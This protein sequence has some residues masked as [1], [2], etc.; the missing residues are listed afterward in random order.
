MVDSGVAGAR[1]GAFR[2]VL[3]VL[4]ADR[5][6]LVV[7]AAGTL[8]AS[9]SGLLVPWL[10]SSAIQ[11]LRAGRW[12]DVGAFAALFAGV[13]ILGA[14]VSAL[15]SLFLGR[16]AN[17]IVG[18]LRERS[19]R[20]AMAIPVSRLTRHPAGDLVSRCANDTEYLGA[21]YREG[22]IQA[23]GVAVVIV[24]AGVGMWLSDWLLCLLVLPL[25]GLVGTVAGVAARPVGRASL[26]HQRALGDFSAE[27]QRCLE[28]L[29]TIRANAADGFA[30]A[31]LGAAIRALV[32]AANRS[33]LARS[34]VGPIMLVS[35]QL[36]AGVVVAVVIWRSLSGG[37]DLDR[38]VA[39]FMYAGM[40]VNPLA[41][42]GSLM[43]AIAVAAG[44]L[45]RL[46][47]LD[48]FTREDPVDTAP[49]STNAPAAGDARTLAVAP[50]VE[51]PASESIRFHHVGLSVPSPRDAEGA[52]TR[53]LHLVDFTVQAGTHLVLT[54]PSGGGKSTIL[55]LIERF[56]APSTGRITLG[57]MDIAALDVTEYRRGLGYVEQGSPLFRGTVR[58][59]LTL[60]S[61]S[62]A[63]RNAGR[64]WAGCGSRT[65]SGPDPM[66][67]RRPWGR[68]GTPS[69]A[70]NGSGWRS[71][72]LCCAG[73]GCCCWTRPPPPS[74][75]APRKPRGRRWRRAG[76]R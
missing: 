46:N 30:L 26:A 38:V 10:A 9:G 43:T 54:G 7:G 64:C 28:S 44:A 34:V 56:Y 12:S 6:A 27:A 13:S 49:A 69:P 8:V 18:S 35:A 25:V 73:R 4:A 42:V 58:D 40:L 52:G 24:G 11:Q 3:R 50:D 65:S 15:V 66:A 32:I 14:V 39:F 57:G 41:Q 45:G 33:L 5:K 70:G 74:M 47:E 75:N 68:A 60:G 19:C 36:A 71:R 2:Q 62:S 61:P 63:T 72:G 37:V 55:A 76:P 21:I 67:W 16:A 20:A 31:R 51:A 17:R 53:I 1:P 59:N 22:P 29:L 48:D 23:M